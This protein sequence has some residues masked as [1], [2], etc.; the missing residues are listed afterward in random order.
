MGA[1]FRREVQSYFT[2]PIGYIFLAA[3]YLFSAF[4]FTSTSI[5]SGS[6]DMKGMFGNLMMILVVLIPILTMRTMA[7]DKR[8]KTD[9]CLLTAPVSLGGIVA[10]KFLAALLVFTCAVAVTVVYAVIVAGFGEVEWMVIIGNILGLE[11][12]GAAFIAI[13]IFCSSLTES[14]VVAAVVSFITIL[15]VNI[16]SVIGSLL[17]WAPVQ[18]LL[19]TLSFYERYTGFTYGLF[20]LSNVLFFISACVIFLFLAVRVLDKRRWA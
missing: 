19:N 7:D 13:G 10:G 6:T 20:D 17:P 8:T 4:F 9:Q 2:S 16:L 12:Y 18:K 14:Q 11:L 5:Q 1:I 3:F 15:A